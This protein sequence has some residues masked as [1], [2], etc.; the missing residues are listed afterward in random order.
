[1]K[2]SISLRIDSNGQ[3]KSNIIHDLSN[4]IQSFLKERNYG[5]DVIELIIGLI[6][7]N[8]PKEVEHLFR[9]KKPDYIDFKV[10]KNKFTGELIELNKQVS[11]DIRLSSEQY[12]LFL[13]L[14]EEGSKKFLAN[15]IFNSLKKFDVLSTKIKKFDKEKLTSDL[16]Y[17]LRENNLII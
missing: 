12:N 5:V 2:F 14:N 7:V 4:S 11:Y 1:M 16:G 15:L 13:S 9:E 3:H 10:I 6:C 17:F 8:T